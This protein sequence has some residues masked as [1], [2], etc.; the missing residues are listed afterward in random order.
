MKLGAHARRGGFGPH[1]DDTDHHQGESGDQDVGADPLAEGLGR[2]AQHPTLDRLWTG[3][4]GR[5]GGW[6]LDVDSNSF[7][8][9]LDHKH[10]SSAAKP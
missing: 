6:V 10:K 7:L 4:R 2:G 9:T 5:G 3:L 8:E 1:L